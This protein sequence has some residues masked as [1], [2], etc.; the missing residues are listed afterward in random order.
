MPT[1]PEPFY[2][3]TDRTRPQPSLPLARSEAARRQR[4]GERLSFPIYQNG[5]VVDL[6]RY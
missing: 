1:A 3:G 5:R 4:A 2:V 6:K